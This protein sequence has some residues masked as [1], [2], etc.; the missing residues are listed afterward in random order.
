MKYKGLLTVELDIEDIISCFPETVA[1]VRTYSSEHLRVTVVR[2]RCHTVEEGAMKRNRRRFA[3][4]ETAFWK[5][6]AQWHGVAKDFW[7]V[8]PIPK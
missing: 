4:L 1:E 5:E 8:A 2:L 7:V 6:Q 3:N